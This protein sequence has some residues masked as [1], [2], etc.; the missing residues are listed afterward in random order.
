MVEISMTLFLLFFEVEKTTRD[1][2]PQRSLVLAMCLAIAMS[3][4]VKPKLASHKLSVFPRLRPMYVISSLTRS[5]S[6]LDTFW[7]MAPP[8]KQNSQ[9]NGQPRLVSNNTTSDRSAGEN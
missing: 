5:S 8:Q 2:K 7:P 4:L 6:N 1:G 3:F 9:A